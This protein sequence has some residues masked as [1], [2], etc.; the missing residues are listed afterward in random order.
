MVSTLVK[1][2]FSFCICLLTFE[3][4]FIMTG[5]PTHH[6]P[7]L[8]QLTEHYFCRLTIIRIFIY[9][10]Q[11]FLIQLIYCITKSW[12]KSIKIMPLENFCSSKKWS[13]YGTSL[14]AAPVCSTHY[15][16]VQIRNC[17]LSTVPLLSK[18]LLWKMQIIF[19]LWMEAIMCNHQIDTFD[20][21][22]D[23][24][25]TKEDIGK[26]PSINFSLYVQRVLF[27]LTPSPLVKAYCINVD[28]TITF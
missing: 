18:Q 12:I 25:D 5:E 15:T 3:K 20:A 28:V 10:N 13:T 6:V 1:I 7:Q 24:W 2:P 26:G 23:G 11:L 19:L 9:D 16:T 4:I 22:K 21:S 14:P 27:F 17:L 8:Y